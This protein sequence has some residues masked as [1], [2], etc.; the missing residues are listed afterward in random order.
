[1]DRDERERR[2]ENAITLLTAVR[3]RSDM[4]KPLRAE[5][6]SL[7]ESFNRRVDFA[8]PT[9]KIAAQYL[10]DLGD[11]GMGSLELRM[12]VRAFVSG[13]TFG[14]AAGVLAADIPQT[15]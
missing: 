1:M 8:E 3:S 10:L 12:I 4:A 14:T 2:V 5:V 7:V 13:A 9:S 15:E 6:L 11:P